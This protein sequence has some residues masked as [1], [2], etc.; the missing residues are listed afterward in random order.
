MK[1]ICWHT[2]EQNPRVATAIAARTLWHETKARHSV[3]KA[4]KAKTL[5]TWMGRPQGPG[6]RGCS[7]AAVVHSCEEVDPTS[8]SGGVVFQD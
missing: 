4:R 6:S 5:L 8:S 7:R 3:T 2:L 1:K